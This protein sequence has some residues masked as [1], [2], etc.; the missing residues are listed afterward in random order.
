MASKSNYEA[1]RRILRQPPSWEMFIHSFPTPE[2]NTITKAIVVMA[3]DNNKTVEHMKL[4]LLDKYYSNIK[5][6]KQFIKSILELNWDEEEEDQQEEEQ[7]DPLP[8]CD[9]D[10]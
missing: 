9:A 1:C 2:A 6:G 10:C 5:E 8:I 4:N 7:E 3:A